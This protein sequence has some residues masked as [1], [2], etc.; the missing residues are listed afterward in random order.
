MGLIRSSKIKGVVLEGE[1][2][3]LEDATVFLVMLLVEG[4]R[5]EAVG[6]LGAEQLGAE[7][8]LVHLA[9]IFDSWRGLML[10]FNANLF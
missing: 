6:V 8:S 2:V 5:L 10:L 3:R 9:T 1:A 7:E 4:T